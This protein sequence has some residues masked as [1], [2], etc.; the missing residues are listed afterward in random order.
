MALNYCNIEYMISPFYLIN[1]YLNDD[2]KQTRGHLPPERDRDSPPLGFRDRP[3][4][5]PK[6]L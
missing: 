3:V 4:T 5:F 1:Q 6:L 2:R